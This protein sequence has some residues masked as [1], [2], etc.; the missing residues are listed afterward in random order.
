MMT[1]LDG[2]IIKVQT[3]Q[4]ELLRLW[5][6]FRWRDECHL[7]GISPVK[8]REENKKSNK[9]SEENKAQSKHNTHNWRSSINQVDNQRQTRD[10]RDE[11]PKEMIIIMIIISISSRRYE[12]AIWTEWHLIIYADKLRAF[13][14]LD[15]E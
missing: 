7:A 9:K 15:Q 3:H 8:N 2:V 4:W 10:K 5:L 13:L 1:Q 14:L 6:S 11:S 12:D